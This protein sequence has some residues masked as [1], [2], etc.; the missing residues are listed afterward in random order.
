MT[1]DTNVAPSLQAA[2][3]SLIKEK[4]TEELE[5]KM[6]NRPTPESLVERNVMKGSEALP[7]NH[8]L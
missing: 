2:R 3:E 5:K 8:F 1:I 6:E 4:L 7:C